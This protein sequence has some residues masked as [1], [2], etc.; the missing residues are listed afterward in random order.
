[1]ICLQQARDHL[2]YKGCRA[3]R[4]LEMYVWIQPTSG[5]AC[6]G[7]R[8]PFFRHP[9]T[10]GWRSK[11]RPSPANNV[12]LGLMGYKS[13]KTVIQHLDLHLEDDLLSWVSHWI[14]QYGLSD[15][16]TSIPLSIGCI[17]LESKKQV[18]A[19]IQCRQKVHISGWSRFFT[20]S[21]SFKGSPV[22]LVVTSTGRARYR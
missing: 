21:L 15:K 14:G 22:P 10:F 16:L 4:W 7:P 17:Y 3:P 20:D 13:E 6:I 1:M 18:V 9:V 12:P 2:K 11:I 19:R 8:T 5:H